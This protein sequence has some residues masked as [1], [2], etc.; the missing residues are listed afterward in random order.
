[1]STESSVYVYKLTS[2]GCFHENLV[3]SFKTIPANGCAYRW[4]GIMLLWG[5]C[6]CSLWNNLVR[7]VMSRQSQ[8]SNQLSC[9]SLKWFV[10]FHVCGCDDALVV[11]LTREH[12]WLFQLRSV[13]SLSNYLHKQMKHRLSCSVREFGLQMSQRVTQLPPALTHKYWRRDLTPSPLWPRA[14]ITALPPLSCHHCPPILSLSSSVA[15]TLV[16]LLL[17]DTHTWVQH[18]RTPPN[19]THT[20][21]PPAFPYEHRLCLP[22]QASEECVVIA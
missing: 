6:S 3:L 9:I 10:W 17:S 18:A 14:T 21:Q 13:L 1:M 4:N 16:L 11:A 2:S 19:H 8:D 20:Q 15:W 22:R 12:S 7:S 5:I